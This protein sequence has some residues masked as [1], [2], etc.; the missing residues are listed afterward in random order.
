MGQSL[1]ANFSRML[2]ILFL[3]LVKHERFKFL[4]GRTG[5][6]NIMLLGRGDLICRRMTLIFHAVVG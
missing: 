4:R 1:K 5:L 2:R 6:F 3:P